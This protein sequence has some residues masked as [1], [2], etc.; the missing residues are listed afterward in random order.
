MLMEAGMIKEAVIGYVPLAIHA[1]AGP[2]PAAV[3][4]FLRNP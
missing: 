3:T 4:T 1:T 2:V